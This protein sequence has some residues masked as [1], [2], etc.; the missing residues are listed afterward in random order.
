MI[1]I[2]ADTDNLYIKVSGHSGYAESGKDIVCA[3]VSSLVFN[4]LKSLRVLVKTEPDC[5][6]ESKSGYIEIIV[7]EKASHKLKKIKLLYKS[8]LLGLKEIENK[9]PDFVR[10]V[11]GG[12]NGS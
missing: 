3:G 9:Y 12:T 2:I 11:K 6:K 4:Y 10:I 1:N 5:K 7:N 8:L